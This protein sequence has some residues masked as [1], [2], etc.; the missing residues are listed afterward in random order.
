MSRGGKPIARSL[1]SEEEIRTMISMGHK[2]G[3]M[4]EAEAKI[5]ERKEWEAK[6]QEK[7]A[8]LKQAEDDLKAVQEALAQE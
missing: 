1:V 8:E 5:Q 6:L 3:T 7:Q 4:E 2:E